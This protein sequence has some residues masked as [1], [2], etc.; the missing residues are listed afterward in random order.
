MRWHWQVNGQ[1]DAAASKCAADVFGAA[2]MAFSQ[3]AQA[4]SRGARPE[5]LSSLQ[6]ACSL[7]GKEDLL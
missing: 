3:A 7:N 4:A 1:G 2:S 5:A 6:R